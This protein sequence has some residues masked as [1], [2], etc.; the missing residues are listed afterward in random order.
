[1]EGTGSKYTSL[2]GPCELVWFCETQTM[3]QAISLEK[4]IKGW[5]REKKIAM[6]EGRWEDLPALSVAYFRKLGV[7]P[8]RRSSFD[9]AQDDDDRD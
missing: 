1:M 6:I 7:T 4:Q 9:G 8:N 2:Q 3:Q 5:R